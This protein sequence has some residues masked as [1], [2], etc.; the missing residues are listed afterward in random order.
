MGT[1]DY[2]IN[3]EEYEWQFQSG[4]YADG[5]GWRILERLG[6][7]GSENDSDQSTEIEEAI[8]KFLESQVKRNPNYEFDDKWY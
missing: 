6:E 1:F 3:N 7:N 4:W 5:A 2:S 8:E